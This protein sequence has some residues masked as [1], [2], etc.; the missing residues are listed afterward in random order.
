MSIIPPIGPPDIGPNVGAQTVLTGNLTIG[1]GVVRYGVGEF[2]RMYWS[3]HYS[4]DKVNVAGTVWAATTENVS[5]A[6]AGFYIQHIAVSGTVA[7]VASAANSEFGQGNATAIFV[8]GNGA[9]INNSGAIYA[10]TDVGLAT[11]IQ[12][13]GP[14]VA[15]TNSGVIAARTGST[16]VDNGSIMQ[17]V[18]L[19][20]FNGAYLH[21]TATGE[22]LAE[23]INATAIIYGRGHV[24][25]SPDAS[26]E[27]T[28]DGVIRAVSLNRGFES[29][30]ILAA[31]LEVEAMEIVNNGLIEADVAIRGGSS[32]WPYTAADEWIS[33][34]A[35]GTIRGDIETVLGDDTLINRGT[36][37]GNVFLG[38][39]DDE[40]DSFG[41]SF[42]GYA[43]LDWGHDTFIGGNG[44]DRV[45]GG[46][47]DDVLSG[48]QNHDLLLGGLGDDHVDGGLG[49]D[50]LY[51]EYGNDTLVLRGADRA[52]GG[53]GAD[54]FILADLAFAGLDG[55][56]GTDRILLPAT[57][58]VH[59]IQAILGDGRITGIEQVELRANGEGALLASEMSSALNGLRILGTE[60]SSL[61]L[62]GSW[63]DNGIVRKGGVTFQ[64]FSANGATVLV[65]RD[66][67][68]TTQASAPS[69][70]VGL[71]A[72]AG[73]SA[74][75]LVESDPDLALA[76]VR[77]T[78]VQFAVEDDTVVESYETWI[79]G[80]E[81]AAI[82]AFAHWATFTNN[83]VI[84]SAF[85]RAISVD[86]LASFTNNGT[87][88]AESSQVG[89]YAVAFQA[90]QW[91]PLYNTGTIIARSDGG[92]AEAASVR[93]HGLLGELGF[94]NSGLIRAECPDGTARGIYIDVAETLAE[95]SG[96]IEAVGGSEAVAVI[97]SSRSLSNSGTIEA[98]AQ[99]PT[100]ADDACA[101]YVR[102]ELGPTEVFNSG[103][104]SGP[105][106]I[107]MDDNPFG[108][109]LLLTNATGGTISG[110]ILLAGA[111]DTITND[112]T[113]DGDVY[114]GSG[115]DR[116][117][118]T[119]GTV[120]GTIFGGDGADRIAV[121]HAGGAN[122]DAGNDTLTGSNGADFL[123]GG[124]G[125][126]ALIG[127]GGADNLT[128]G[129]GA[130][131]FVFAAV[132]D[133][134]TNQRDRILD[135]SAA[136]HD[137]VD[138]SAIDAIAG[139]GDDAFTLADT[140]HR[141]AGELV[142]RAIAEGRWRVFG[143]A[144]GNGAA[145]FAIDVYAAAAPTILD[146]VL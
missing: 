86:L 89:G 94:F 58:A 106:A 71:S 131:R 2:L 105:T 13:W 114:L 125:R 28:N 123:L 40:F 3:D 138:L 19:A 91:V 116:F 127:G 67:E 64:S 119:N 115:A 9:S 141:I 142:V 8:G 41:G 130:D 108:F 12:H 56:Q 57:S 60:T 83:G 129:V 5:A 102:A 70:L 66:V 34:S 73:G 48:N 36:L 145:D 59:N 93:S 68:V 63:T 111:A 128:G 4:I 24:H 136:Q 120:T 23:G 31:H 140:F 110:Q 25:I 53:A 79:G 107:F 29:V 117:H 137:L 103:V 50:G 65:E 22:I 37:Q 7:A 85:G 101:L 118:G 27:I 54:L 144:D 33:N 30:G 98:T 84:K 10:A 97:L 133:S 146:F 18:A 90:N 52:F 124:T 14:D 100:T 11:A 42:I 26:H 76:G 121:G 77:Q 96:R 62:V 69:G 17:A 16:V 47:M 80:P 6:I 15:I 126:D 51:G 75:R 35:S 38:I 112:G 61:V 95:N 143:D 104:I 122:G 82:S 87:I 134:L 45:T 1:P 78:D 109:A 55:G 88:L 92:L 43:D 46:R 139:G 49:N 21:N 72:V 99:S 44:R 132:S 32:T 74:A 113:I 81:G 135:F 39:G 20:A